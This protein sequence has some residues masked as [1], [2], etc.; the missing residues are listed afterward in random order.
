MR[1]GEWYRNRWPVN[2]V[3]PMSSRPR[4]ASR[5]CGT[6]NLA[7]LNVRRMNDN[8]V[9]DALPVTSFQ[10]QRSR[11]PRNL[12]W[13]GD[14]AHTVPPRVPA[15]VDRTH[16]QIVTKAGCRE[17]TTFEPAEQFVTA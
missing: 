13:P 1:A 10:T 7:P 6:S 3:H 15:R 16:R 17:S 14:G 12:P 9:V 2:S 11:V 8:A 4:M 5:T